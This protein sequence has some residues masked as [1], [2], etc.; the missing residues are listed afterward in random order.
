VKV[1]RRRICRYRPRMI[2]VIK[3]STMK[4]DSERR[5]VVHLQFDIV[6]PE[7]VP[8]EGSLMGGLVRSFCQWMK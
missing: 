6:L 3:R 1:A 5:V 2:R 4:R 8:I 7:K